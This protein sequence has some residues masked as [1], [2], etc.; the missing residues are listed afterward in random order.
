MAV[1]AYRCPNCSEI[2]VVF[3]IGT[4]SA[5]ASCPDCGATSVRVFSAPML[6]RTPTALSAQLQRAERSASEPEVVTSP[7]SRRGG[8]KV[9]V[10][11]ATSRLPRP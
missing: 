5:S 2:E 3:P 7:P 8:P 4:A 1:Y 10:H 11:P 9:G 6:A